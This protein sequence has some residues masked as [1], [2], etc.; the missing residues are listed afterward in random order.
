MAHGMAS[1][2]TVIT[3]GTPPRLSS[4]IVYSSAAG[5]NDGPTVP[6]NR[7]FFPFRQLTALTALWQDAHTEGFRRLSNRSLFALAPRSRFMTDSHP[8]FTS[9]AGGLS[10]AESHHGLSLTNAPNLTTRRNTLPHAEESMSS[11]F[12]PC[13]AVGNGY[14]TVSSRSR[15][16]CETGGGQGE[17]QQGAFGGI[18]ESAIGE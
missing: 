14:R 13:A 6:T 3:S 9:G 10:W 16:I 5:Q 4:R 18:E 12:H 15:G 2:S 11:G 1:R 7:V 8:I 17:Y